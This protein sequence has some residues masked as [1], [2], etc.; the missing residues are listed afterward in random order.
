M[1]FVGDRFHMGRQS[2]VIIEDAEEV[3]IRKF[4][5]IPNR[6]APAAITGTILLRKGLFSS[7]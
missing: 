5:S 6:S 7:K 4:K 3:G 2:L 1:N